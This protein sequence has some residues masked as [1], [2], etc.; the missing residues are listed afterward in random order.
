MFII[1]VISVFHDFFLMNGIQDW[2]K[3]YADRSKDYIEK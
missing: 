1:D 2:H 3:K